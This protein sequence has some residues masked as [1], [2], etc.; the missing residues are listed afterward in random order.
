MHPTCQ[1][2]TL[3]AGSDGVM[4]WEM[5]SWHTLSPLIPIEHRSVSGL[6]K[7]KKQLLN[8]VG[9]ALAG[10]EELKQVLQEAWRTY[11]PSSLENYLRSFTKVL[12]FFFLL[13]VI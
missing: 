10:T 9:F 12:I 11:Q 13:L 4:V 1:V 7:K 3:Q 5:F 2:S 6:K 8:H